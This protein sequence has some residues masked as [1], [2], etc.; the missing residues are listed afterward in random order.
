MIRMIGTMILYVTDSQYMK[1][2]SS[3]DSFHETE[4]N[5]TN[6]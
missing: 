6:N 4:R 3:F 1:W 5:I 2:S